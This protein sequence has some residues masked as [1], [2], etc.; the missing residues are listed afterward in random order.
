[1]DAPHEQSP[2]EHSNPVLASG[3]FVRYRVPQ[4][5]AARQG[6]QL[7]K[8]DRGNVAFC[9]DGG[10]AELEDVVRLRSLDGRIACH[11]RGSVLLAGGPVQ[12]VDPD[13]LAVATVARVELS[14]VRDQFFVEVG[15][16]TTW[17]VEGAVAAYEY[18]IGGR[19]GAIAEVS[20]RWFRAPGFYG[21]Q[22][23]AG[24]SALLVL[25]VAVCLDLTI[26][27]RC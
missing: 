26:R 14:P 24:Q 12:I 15:E 23:S 19:D 21:V 9:V 8:D 17:A 20:R 10:S 5:V 3:S 27:A 1:M 4:N 22:V 18:R 11:I 6:E 13:G 16:R 25:A 2:D 7:V